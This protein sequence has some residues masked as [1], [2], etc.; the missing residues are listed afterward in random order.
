LSAS[1]AGRLSPTLATI[2]LSPH[3]AVRT[4]CVCVCVCVYVLHAIVDVPVSIRNGIRAVSVDADYIVSV[5]KRT[6]ANGAVC[7][8]RHSVY[9]FIYSFRNGLE[10]SSLHEYDIRRFRGY[11]S[12]HFAGIFCSFLSRSGCRPTR[13]LLRMLRNA[14]LS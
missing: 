12:E 8:A 1:T 10:R 9:L 5:Y 3:S 4:Q 7:V 14:R 2:S 13:V 6:A 11:I